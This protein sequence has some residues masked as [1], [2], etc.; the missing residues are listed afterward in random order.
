MAFA[1]NAKS[2]L[3][4]GLNSTNSESSPGI[5]FWGWGMA[6]TNANSDAL[7]LSWE[8][9]WKRKCDESLRLRRGLAVAF[10]ENGAERHTVDPNLSWAWRT[11]WQCEDI[12]VYK[13]EGGDVS[14]N[15]F[16]ASGKAIFP[17]FCR[18]LIQNCDLFSI[19][20]YFVDFCSKLWFLYVL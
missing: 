2:E 13:P 6:F 11:R 7:Q 4:T 16:A 17:Y 9:K 14:G 1:K 3:S 10:G 19:L 12:P 20:C 5:E 18:F 15:R 8:P